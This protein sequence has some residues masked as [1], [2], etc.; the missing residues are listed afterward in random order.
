VESKKLILIGVVIAIVVIGA[1]YWYF[2]TSQKLPWLFKGAYAKYYGETTVLFIP[3]KLNV[4]LEVL[5]FNST[6]AKLLMYAKLETPFGSHEYQD[7]GWSDLTKKTYKIEGAIL[8]KSYEQEVYLEGI[9]VR[10]CNVYEYQSKTEPKSLMIMY[11]D[12]EVVWPIK[13]KYTTEA[14]KMMPS[15]SLDLNL[16]ESNIPG[17]KKGK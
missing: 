6:H 10:K 4:R 11:V 13:I 12:K 14:T 7:V 1:G 8:K 9:G 16:V 15:M 5:D 17:L 3:V 2:T